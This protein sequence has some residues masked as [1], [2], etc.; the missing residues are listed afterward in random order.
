MQDAYLRL[1]RRNRKFT[2]EREGY[3]YLKRSVVNI[4]IDFYRT[5]SRYRARIRSVPNLQEKKDGCSQGALMKMIRE[6]EEEYKSRV[7]ERLRVGVNAL[8]P[9]QRETVEE[10]FFRSPNQT[11]REISERLDVPYS[12]LRSRLGRALDLLQ[13]SVTLPLP[14][15][16][17]K[18]EEVK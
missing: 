15:R 5:Q 6:E 11:L 9:K 3:N 17:Q 2:S 10:I 12:T 7:L 13:D 16:N 14:S 18:K 1:L 8:P 4:A